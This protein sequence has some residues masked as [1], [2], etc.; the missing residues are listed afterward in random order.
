MVDASSSAAAADAP[1]PDP[2]ATAGGA[3][4]RWRLLVQ[5]RWLA[6][7]LFA[8]VAVV[9]MLWLGDWQFRRAQG[10]NAL[11]WA[12]TFEWPIFAVFGV[13]FWIKT[14]RDELVP[15]DQRPPK[16][17]PVQL[18]AGIG[19]RGHA[20]PGAGAARHDGGP[21]DDLA[22]EQSDAEPTDTEL[23]EYNAY[24]ARL[25]KETRGHGKW[26]GLR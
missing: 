21:A 4:P 10:G 26:H 15:P 8:V 3:A 14:I 7:H 20:G 25:T 23:A 24:L 22:A 13:V 9:G 6:W 1:A 5:P 11:S 16:A 2:G 19:H 12:Y 17:E 18:P